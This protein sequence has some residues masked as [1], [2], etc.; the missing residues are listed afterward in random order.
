VGFLVSI[1]E[2]LCTGQAYLPTIVFVTR[3][4]HLRAAAVAY[5]LLYNVMFIV[6]LL[7]I[8]AATYLGVRSETLGNLLRKRLSLAKFAMAG[9]FAG[10]ALFLMM[11]RQRFQ[12]GHPLDYVPDMPNQ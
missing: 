2:S 6:P 11:T 9:L 5:L 8:L 12:H 10:L 4:P 1:L 7:A 3:V